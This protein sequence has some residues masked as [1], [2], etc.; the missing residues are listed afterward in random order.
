MNKIVYD[1]LCM[2]CYAYDSFLHPQLPVVYWQEMKLISLQYISKQLSL[3]VNKTV[4]G[5]EHACCVAGSYTI[6]LPVQ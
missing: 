1:L 3:E 5:F 6:D 2:T 4:H